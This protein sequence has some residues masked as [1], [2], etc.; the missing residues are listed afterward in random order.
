M[1]DNGNNKTFISKFN[2]VLSK[3]CKTSK[4]GIWCLTPLSTIFQLDRGVKLVCY[5]ILT[6]MHRAKTNNETLK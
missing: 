2:C 5:H 6:P 3:D 1:H 4:I